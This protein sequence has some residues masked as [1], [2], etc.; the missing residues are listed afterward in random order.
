MEIRTVW[1]DAGSVKPGST[2]RKASDVRIISPELTSSTRASA[3]CVTTSTLRA[4]CRSRLPVAVRPPPRRAFQTRGPPCLNAG[5]SPNSSPQATE[6]TSAK[7]RL[8]TSSE[9]SLRRGRLAGPIATRTRK[10]P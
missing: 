10:P 7:A 5:S 9:I 4:R 8:R 6:I 3:T 1:I 2:L